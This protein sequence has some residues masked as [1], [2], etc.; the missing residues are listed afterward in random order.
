MREGIGSEHIKNEIALNTQTVIERFTVAGVVC[1]IDGVVMNAGL[2]GLGLPLI[3]SILISFVFSAAGT[4]VLARRLPVVLNGIRKRKPWLSITWLIIGITALLQTA[5]ISVFMIDPAHSQ[6]SVFPGDKWFVEHCCLTAYSESA[7]LVM[8]EEKNIYDP[9][10]YLNRKESGFNVDLYHYPP[11]FLLLPIMVRAAAGNDFLS[12]RAVWFALNAL[13]LLLAICLVIYRLEPENRLKAIGSAPLIW[14]SIPVMAGLQMSNVQIMVVSIS[15]IAWAIFP[16]KAAFGGALLAMSSVAKIFPGILFLYLIVKRKWREVM[17][18][19]G[20]A[21]ALTLLAF[22]IIGA[23]PF[24]SFIEYEMPRLS[25]GEAFSRP[26]SRSFAVARNMAPFG[27]PLK[28]G[29]LG[30][31]GIT[32]EIG[33]IISMIY[34]AVIAGLAVWAARR[35]PHSVTESFSVWISLLSLGTLASPFAPANYVL[36]SLIILICLNREIFRLSSLLVIWLII[37][38]PFLISREAPFLVQMLFNLPAQALAIGIP[39]YILWKAGLKSSERYIDSF[40]PEREETKIIRI[41][42]N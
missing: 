24:K 23:S 19:A 39:V 28:L 31:S 34:V 38:I 18:T 22:L 17:W 14:I 13:T 6:F 15:T 20:I 25:S 36:S 7:R 11:P 1:L 10:N 42:L 30:V 9:Q 35:K 41:P 32:P 5:R 40:L 21:V 27:I 26:F 3:L 2:W 12:V 33:R 29:W 16:R 4:M 37:F 8:S